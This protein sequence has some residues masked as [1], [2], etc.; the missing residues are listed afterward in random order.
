MNTINY[1]KMD[2]AKFSEFSPNFIFFRQ[3]NL[4]GDL[5]PNHRNNLDTISNDWRKIDEEENQSLPSFFFFRERTI[6][7]LSRKKQEQKQERK[8]EKDSRQKLAGSERGQIT[9][10]IS[11]SE[12]AGSSNNLSNTLVSSWLPL[13]GIRRQRDN[14]NLGPS[15][16]QISPCAV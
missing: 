12:F 9:K 14:L 1:E 13:H 5:N 2:D 10:G 3:P 16:D 7:T 11:S 15:G 4:K 8:R 6:P